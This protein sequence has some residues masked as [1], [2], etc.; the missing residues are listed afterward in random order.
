VLGKDGEAGRCGCSGEEGEVETK[1]HRE[2]VC[3]RGGPQLVQPHLS[4]H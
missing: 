3:T 2:D 1:D 4:S